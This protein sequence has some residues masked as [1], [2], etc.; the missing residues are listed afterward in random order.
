MLLLPTIGSVSPHAL[1]KGGRSQKQIRIDK[2]EY[3]AIPYSFIAF[4]CGLI[5]GDGYIRINKSTK[6]FIVINLVITLSI[7]DISTLEYIY[8]VLK[9]G[10]II[11]YKDYKNPICNLIINK[12]DLQ[13]VLFPLFIHHNIFFLTKN[14]RN[15]FDLAMYIY[16]NNIKLFNLISEIMDLPTIFELP[17]TATEYLS[18]PFF[19]N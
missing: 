19:K 3:L 10:K 18:L 4:F 14:R 11:K 1:K 6:G 13:E 16:K 5:D 8:S 12:T 9:I 17:N 2:K 15:Q 7:E